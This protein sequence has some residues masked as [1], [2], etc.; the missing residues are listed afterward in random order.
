MTAGQ[1]DVT[2]KGEAHPWDGRPPGSPQAV[3]A[4]CACPRID[5]HHGDGVPVG[6]ERRWH[7]SGSCHLHYDLVGG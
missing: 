5:N 2:R 6:G 4:G 7:I 3:G 1:S